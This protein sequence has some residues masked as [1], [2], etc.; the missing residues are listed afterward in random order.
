MSAE[1]QSNRLPFEPRQKNKKKSPKTPAKTQKTEDKKQSTSVKAKNAAIPE[2]VSQR[3]IRRMALFCGIPSFLA[4]ST[5][6]FSYLLISQVHLEIPTPAVLITSSAFFALGVVGLSY[7]VLSASWDENR[8]GD[9][10]GWQEFTTN[11]SRMRSAWRES[12]QA[13]KSK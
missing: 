9:W 13:A 4:I 2:I 12:K 11:F 10:W 6:V 7:G 1:P 8:V 5:F 3:M